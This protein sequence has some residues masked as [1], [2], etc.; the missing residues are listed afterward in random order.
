MTE[1]GA[2]LSNP[3][4]LILTNGKSA[5]LHADRMEEFA[6]GHHLEVVES[7]INDDKAF[8]KI[9]YY[10]E[11][12]SVSTILIRSVWDVSRDKE[13]LY[14]LLKLASE[15]GASVNEEERDWQVATIVWDGG[16]GY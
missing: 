6:L 15:H 8:E 14:Q 7:L 9:Q 3:R 16:N 2:A 10:L 1:Y 13:K 5:S 4:C 12:D 11:H